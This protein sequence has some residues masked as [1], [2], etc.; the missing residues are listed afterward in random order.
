VSVCWKHGGLDESILW[1]TDWGLWLRLILDGSPVGAVDESLALYRIRETS[2]TAKRREL[3]LGKI[4]THSR[5][6]PA[7]TASSR[8][9]ARS[10]K[11]RS[12]PTETRS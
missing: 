9:N 5:R 8:V 4:S 6:R 12:R 7:A 10:S 11:Q 2:L 3:A 1:T